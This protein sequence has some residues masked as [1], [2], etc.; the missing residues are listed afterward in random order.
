MPRERPANRRGCVSFNL[1]H[2]SHP[3]RV[4]VSRFA[5]GRLAEI[6]LDAGKVNS[7]LQQHAETSAILVSLLLQHGV[8]V[9]TIRHSISG[10]IAVA[11]D[12]AEQAE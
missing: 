5:D 9:E 1:D 6:F 7:P 2:E 11:L 8:N 10:P 12:M 4:C 3:Y